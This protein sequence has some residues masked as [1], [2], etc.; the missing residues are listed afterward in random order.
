MKAGWELG[1]RSGTG[2]ETWRATVGSTSHGMHTYFK[3][4]HHPL[5][6]SYS[7]FH[8]IVGLR[9]I[10][11]L[12]RD[13][14][15]R[16]GILTQDIQSLTMTLCELTFWRE[17]TLAAEDGYPRPGLL[18]SLFHGK[19]ANA[20]LFRYC[21]CD[22]SLG[23][24]LKRQIVKDGE[25]EVIHQ[26]TARTQAHLDFPDGD[27]QAFTEVTVPSVYVKAV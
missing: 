26:S 21:T 1:N 24:S 6:L 20:S 19:P 16:K 7:H 22:R 18:T 23:I 13:R 15:S 25:G 17:P 12:P 2:L 3:N 11:E 27:Y 14:G 10:P 5:A 8:A 4:S 9:T